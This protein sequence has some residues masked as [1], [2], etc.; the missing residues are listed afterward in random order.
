VAW[1]INCAVYSKIQLCH[2]AHSAAMNRT[3]ADHSA[4][5][6]KAAKT[7]GPE[8]RSGAAKKAARTRKKK[9]A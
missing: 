8:E 2:Q 7:K 3:G 6:R 5:A 1:H 9:M 4:T